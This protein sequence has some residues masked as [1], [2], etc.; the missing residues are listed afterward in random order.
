LVRRWSSAN[1]LDARKR[2]SG[3]G[4]GEEKVLEEKG[5]E[6]SSVHKLR[7]DESD[8]RRKSNLEAEQ[9]NRRDESVRS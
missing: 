6:A 4:Q 2:S 7:L 3:S 5:S 8:L 1:T 9:K